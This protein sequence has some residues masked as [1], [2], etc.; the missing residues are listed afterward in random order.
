MFGSNRTVIIFDFSSDNIYAV[1]VSL[2]K[3]GARYKADILRIDN[4]DISR[5][6]I[7]EGGIIYD[8]ETVKS[9]VRTLITNIARD[10][11]KIDT[12]WIVV[13]S[14]KAEI[15][16][17]DVLKESFE[18]QDSQFAAVVE[19]AF[20]TPM[21]NLHVEY[22][23]IHEL[24]NRV[25]SLA[26]GIKHEHLSPYLQIFSELNLNVEVAYPRFDAL[27]EE[28]RDY[29][30]IPTLFLY[31]YKRG[32]KFLVADV[33]GV[34]MH[35][36]GEHNI[37]DF[38]EHFDKA[39]IE[40]ISYA[41]RDKNV[42]VPI[43]KILVLE[44]HDYD[45][46]MVELYLRKIGI[47]YGWIKLEDSYGYDQLTILS[48]KGAIKKALKNETGL[49]SSENNQRSRDTT[50]LQSSFSYLSS[51]K[52]SEETNFRNSYS[53]YELTQSRP[54]VKQSLGHESLYKPRQKYM[55]QEN[56]LTRYI[57]IED[58]KGSL[59]NWKTVFVTTI[60][61]FIILALVYLVG[62][63]FL[64]NSSNNQ[65]NTSQNQNMTDIDI[66][67]SPTNVPTPTLDDDFFF[68]PTETIQTPSP[69]PTSI[70]FGKSDV[71]VKV[72]N[73]TTKAFEAARISTILKN[74]GFNTLE[75]ANHTSN[76]V[77]NTIIYYRDQR[78]E[79]LA[80]EIV[81]LIESSYPTASIKYD[82]TISFDI[83]VVLGAN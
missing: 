66:T 14:N 63:N 13:P 77:A 29:F 1:L 19:D 31:P 40:V 11:K 2:V 67:S 3:S 36:I 35:A 62:I 38:N 68:V 52:P 76:N 73:G 23:P 10:Q 18:L 75:P 56:A 65:I 82:E 71:K 58:E 34:H 42:A 57:D 22:K 28:K 16:K 8:Y 20:R 37:V 54:V 45:A 32:F 21:Q 48:I 25:Y 39:L 9:Y 80:K 70:P 78:S 7:I 27:Y 17:F 30:D 50:K 46:E 33:D 69:T 49:I 4:V 53:D 24:N 81:T 61:V 72:H 60:V 6:E 43:K 83:L 51:R 74:N 15:V 79:A 26:Y 47:S 55:T 5:S 59:L 12:A 44:S 64:R 41:K